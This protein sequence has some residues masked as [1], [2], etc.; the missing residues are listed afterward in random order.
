MST[1]L[2]KEQ[3]IAV[4]KWFWKAESVKFLQQEFQRQFQSKPPIYP[5]IISLVKKLDL[6]WKK[7][8][9]FDVVWKKK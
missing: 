4:L 3:E 6:V 2:Q 9:K 8:K 5:A 1:R 7:S